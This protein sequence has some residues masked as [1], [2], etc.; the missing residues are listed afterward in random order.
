MQVLDVETERQEA[1]HHL[2]ED[3]IA[4]LHRKVQAQAA[5]IQRLQQLL[6]AHGIDSAKVANEDTMSVFGDLVSLAGTSKPGEDCELDL[7]VMAEKD[8]RGFLKK[9]AE[10]VVGGK[11]E[12]LLPK[13][14]VRFKNLSVI[15]K[16]KKAGGIQTVAG[17]F[18]DCFTQCFQE[19][20]EVTLLNSLSGVFKPSRLTLVLGPPGA[21]K[22]TLM[23][24]LSNKLKGSGVKVHGEVTYNG[25]HINTKKFVL[26]K[27]VGYVDQRD[28]HIAALTVSETIH[29]ARQGMSGESFGYESILDGD[30]E[31][32]KAL[33]DIRA[34]AGSKADTLIK[35]LGLETCKDTIVGND[36]L[37]GVSGGQRK[38]VTLGEM[39]AGNFISLFLDEIS[40]G[41]DSAATLDITKALRYATDIFKYS[42]V[43]ALLQPAP[44]VYAQFDDIL[45]MDSGNIVYHGERAKILGYFES[46]GF[47]C[48][49]RKDVADYLQ[50]VTTKD[51][52]QYLMPEQELK[53]NNITPPKNTAEFVQRWQETT[54]AKAMQKELEQ[55]VAQ[56]QFPD[57]LRHEFAQNFVASVALCSKMFWILLQRDPAAVRAPVGQNIVLGIIMGIVFQDLAKDQVQSK[58]GLIFMSLMNF[59][60]AGMSTL[61][62]GFA[63]RTVFYKQRDANFYRTLAYCIAQNVV[64]LPVSIIKVVVFCNIVYWVTGLSDD[65]GGFHFFYFMLVC[66]VGCGDLTLRADTSPPFTF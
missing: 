58:M 32:L 38:R 19:K 11:G 25:E 63:Q 35:V 52:N 2:D 48:P 43:C 45:L 37:R 57:E 51:G 29:M 23:K 6:Q 53:A 8:L 28:N 16:Q 9:I 47:R 15:S 18:K 14:E 36:L 46:L 64:N 39:M 13:M 33:E 59:S 3:E 21:G 49:A 20:V 42:I 54:Q 44:E 27:L 66:L 17:F 62:D 30:K 61:P 10:A 50:E 55:P 40:T 5:F 4:M 22:S 7:K 56:Y 1:P 34:S 60:L 24:A 12:D 41:L 65:S 26:R 31:K